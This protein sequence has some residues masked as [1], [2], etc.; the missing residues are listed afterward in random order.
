MASESTE[1][2]T[3]AIAGAT[4][5]VGTALRRA[6]APTYRIIGLTRSPVRA[7]ANTTPTNGEIWRH[8]DLFDPQAVHEALRD[9]DY[10][11]YLVHSMHPSSRLTQASVADLDLL[12]ADNFARAAEAQGVKQL[13]YVGG[14]VPSHDDLSS[15]LQSRREVQATLASGAVPLTTL[16]AGLIVGRGGTWLRLLINLV[17]R[18]P[19]MILPSW[20]TASLRPIA[21]DDVVRALQHCL[22]APDAYDASYDIGGPDVMTYREMIERTAATLGLSRHLIQSS[23]DAPALSKLWVRVFSGAP[24][25]LVSPLIDRMRHDTP[26]SDN[27]LQ[28]WLEADATSYTTALQASIDASGAPHPNPREAL[29]D[30]DDAMIRS[31]SVARSVQRLPLPPGYT[32][33]DIAAEYIRWLPTMGG[34][35]LNCDVIDGRMVRFRVP[36]LGLTLLELTLDANG[37]PDERQAF[38]VTG[39][40]LADVNHAYTGRLEFR[41]ALNGE[42]VIAAVH[43][44]APRLPWYVYNVTQAIAHLFVMAGFRKH[45]A[46]IAEH[47][48]A[49]A[50]DSPPQPAWP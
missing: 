31:T 14:L 44:F 21:L 28:R 16:R 30:A 4:G 35:L 46:R 40:V 42:C 11:V 15:Y 13:L 36:P 27:P 6:L 37:H 50:D 18:L 8:C 49:S 9:A 26:V 5:F 22:G 33:R 38:H 32:A 29:R 43:D 23:I 3:V 48:P 45:L 12:Q 20:A 17:D 34:P 10:A 24:W 39:G 41:Q 2:P 19:V 1:R 47:T 25:A 7:Q